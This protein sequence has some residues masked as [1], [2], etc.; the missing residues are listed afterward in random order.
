MSTSPQ[1][2]ST[3]SF[4]RSLKSLCLVP[5]IW[6]PVMGTKAMSLDGTSAQ[7]NS[8][9]LWGRSDHLEPL[10]VREMLLPEDAS[11]TP[12]RLIGCLL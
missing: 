8:A 4:Q 9:A 5:F 3:F 1:P 11:W 12:G 7:S 2:T 10:P 6:L